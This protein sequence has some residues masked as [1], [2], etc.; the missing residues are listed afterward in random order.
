MVA[1]LVSLAVPCVAQTGALISLLAERSLG[2]VAGLFLL[3]VAA[4]LLAGVLLHRLLPGQSPDTV[5]EVP[6][7]LLPRGDV[8]LKRN[9]QRL[10]NFLT[11]GALPMVA[12]V[13][14]AALLYETGLMSHIGRLLSPLVVTW[15]HLP[16]EAA[17]P[18]VL[19]IF[20][21]ELAVLPLLDMDLTTLQLATG[22]VVGL[23]YVPC[24]AMV[25][26]LG[27][28]FGLRMALGVLVIT[29]SVAFLM[30]GIIA[31]LGLGL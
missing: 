16:Q 27:R 17:T 14:V 4:L 19:G 18:L 9:W 2:A 20:R 10:K 28:E 3:S 31:R 7:L 15:L 23:F 21:R 6:E 8:I 25:G 22:A 12:A 26:V 13:G 30:G 11:D 29:T 24:I 1:A 5:I